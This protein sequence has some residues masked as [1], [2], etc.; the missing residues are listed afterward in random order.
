M[1]IDTIEAQT[2]PS[3]G[4]YDAPL[5]S[6]YNITPIVG[7]ISNDIVFA[8]QYSAGAKKSVLSSAFSG[9]NTCSKNAE[10]SIYDVPILMSDEHSEVR[11]FSFSSSL[12]DFFFSI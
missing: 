12:F 4:A 1:S 10:D 6:G 9:V 2:T 7:E 5:T 11:S 8:G 3:V